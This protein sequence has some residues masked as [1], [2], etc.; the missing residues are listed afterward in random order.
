MDKNKNIAEFYTYNVVLTINYLSNSLT[1]RLYLV[2]LAFVRK[3]T[4]IPRIADIIKT[5]TYAPEMIKLAGYKG[6]DPEAYQPATWNQVL[7][8]YAS[9]HC[10][11]PGEHISVDEKLRRFY[12]KEGKSKQA[13]EMAEERLRKECSDVDELLAGNTEALKKYEIL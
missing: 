4:Q 13:I 10:G 2:L 11:S 7:I 12:A 1:S 8:D 6:Y 9:M 5:H 3:I